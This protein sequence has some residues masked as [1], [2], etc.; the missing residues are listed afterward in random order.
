MAIELVHVFRVRSGEHVK[1]C[2]GFDLLGKLRGG[3]VTEDD[4]G[5][6]LF[7]EPAA[8]S[9]KAPVRFEAA[10]TASF[11]LDSGAAQPLRMSAAAVSQLEKRILMLSYG[12]AWCV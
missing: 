1:R 7:A 9:S 8:I 10:A 5:P 3:A 6:G 2:S 4:L 11:T 12:S